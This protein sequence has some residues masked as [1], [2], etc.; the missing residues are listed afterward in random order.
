MKPIRTKLDDY[1]TECAIKSLYQNP[2]D[3]HKYIV[4]DHTNKKQFMVILGPLEDYT[5]PD[6]F[7]E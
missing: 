6:Y 3:E 2:T 4:V 7:E 1:V 5:G